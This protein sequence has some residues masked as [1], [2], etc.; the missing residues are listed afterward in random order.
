MRKTLKIKSPDYSFS[1]AM[2]IDDSD[3]DNFINQRVLEASFFAEKIYT[4]TNGLS[5]IEFLENLYVNKDC[6]EEMIPDV[7][8][9]DL[10]MPLVNGFQFIEK[11]F[12]LPDI[13]RSCKIV[14][15]TSSVNPNDKATA[16]ALNKD[17]IF[18][19]KPLHEEAIKHLN[20]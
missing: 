20:E 6:V 15:L 7:I 2:L 10:N 12:E 16:A 18:L 17:I 1:K 8:F 14:I 5:A 13:F 4:F 11:F 19:H 3:M 9:V